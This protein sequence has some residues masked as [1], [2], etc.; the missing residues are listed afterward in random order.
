[1]NY[2]ASL[3]TQQIIVDSLEFDNNALCTYKLSLP[4]SAAPGSI[5]TV[6]F[7]YTMST[8]VGFGI[9]SDYTTAQGD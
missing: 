7:P 5:M 2:V 8:G 9:G 6:D 4:E 1:M 3:D